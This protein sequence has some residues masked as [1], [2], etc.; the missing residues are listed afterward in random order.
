MIAALRAF[1]AG[2]NAWL[3]AAI[4]AIVGAGG[5][6]IQQ[7]RVDGAKDQA[8]RYE[9]QYQTMR[10]ALTL[11]SAALRRCKT[12]NQQNATRYAEAVHRAEAAEAEALRLEGSA[13][14]RVEQIHEEAKHHAADTECRALADPLPADFVRWLRH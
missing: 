1:T 7:V 5:I 4:V 13:N 3:L 12:I 11:E 10:N 8:A 14:T 6:W 2:L 9:M